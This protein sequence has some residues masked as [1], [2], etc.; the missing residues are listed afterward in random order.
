MIVDFFGGFGLDALSRSTDPNP[1]PNRIPVAS[2]GMLC[3][4]RLLAGS[5]GVDA[6]PGK[7]LG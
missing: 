3:L 1:N 7:I 2:A 4:V 5:A 6:D